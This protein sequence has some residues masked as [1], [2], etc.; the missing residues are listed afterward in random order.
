MYLKDKGSA[1]GLATA[2][3]EMEELMGAQLL[4]AEKT[5]Q[6]RRDTLNVVQ[7]E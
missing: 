2:A 7:G 5:A 1:I 4:K 6:L 3:H